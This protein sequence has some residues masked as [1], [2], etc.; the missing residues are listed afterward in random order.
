MRCLQHSI[1]QNLLVCERTK[2]RA[3][4]T[5][6]FSLQIC[7]AR[8]CTA[9]DLRLYTCTLCAKVLGAKNF[10]TDSLH[11]FNDHGISKLVCN[12]CVAMTSSK[13]KALKAQLQ[14][15][16]RVCKCFCPI[17]KEK[18]P[19]APVCYGE[20][21]WPGSDGYISKEDKAFLDQLSPRPE[22]WSR[23]WG[24]R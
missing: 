19:L 20:R 15:S 21:R 16:K 4:A 3:T 12:S 9:H 23:A 1:P 14:K 11:N 22:W 7:R 17:H 6:S 13:E 10:G 24:R 2:Q 5:H 8:G 18:C